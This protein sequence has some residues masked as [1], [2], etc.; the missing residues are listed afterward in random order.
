MSDA[1][2]I[3]YIWRC[4][5]SNYCDVRRMNFTCE[6]GWSGLD[7]EYGLPTGGGDEGLGIEAVDAE[8]LGVKE[9]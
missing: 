4:V 2:F 6:R 7:R 8:V 3:S 5:W 9:L 1:I